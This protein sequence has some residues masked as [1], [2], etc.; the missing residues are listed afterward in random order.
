M[1]IEEDKNEKDMINIKLSEKEFEVLKMGFSQELIAY[2]AFRHPQ[3]CRD[4]IKIYNDLDNTM[5]IF[6]ERDWQEYEKERQ[7]KE[8]KY[9]EELFEEDEDGDNYNPFRRIED[10]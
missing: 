10:K 6:V 3:F 9:K 4:Y 8:E 2:Y 7:E 1:Y 5:Q